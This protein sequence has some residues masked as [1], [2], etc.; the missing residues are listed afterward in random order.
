MLWTK[1]RI[2][3]FLHSHHFWVS[4]PHY[5]GALP[6]CHFPVGRYRL[7]HGLNWLWHHYNWTCRV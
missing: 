7:V 2:R 5:P 1:R 4:T 3:T 6:P